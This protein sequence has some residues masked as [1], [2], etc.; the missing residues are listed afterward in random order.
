MLMKNPDGST[1]PGQLPHMALFLT[2]SICLQQ[3]MLLCRQ[4]P[5]AYTDTHCV[6]TFKQHTYAG[7]LSPVQE[8]LASTSAELQSQLLSSILKSDRKIQGR[9]AAD[10]DCLRALDL[11]MVDLIPDTRAFQILEDI[12]KVPPCRAIPLFKLF[13]IEVL[14]CANTPTST[15]EHAHAAGGSCWVHKNHAMRVKVQKAVTQRKTMSCSR[16]AKA[17]LSMLQSLHVGMQCR[18][19]GRCQSPS[20]CWSPLA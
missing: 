7:D 8:L 18:C 1:A 6:L 12:L 13:S 11:W 2:W 19:L 3:R 14:T 17:A 15:C 20:I 4:C 10:L 16:L 5:W 9:L